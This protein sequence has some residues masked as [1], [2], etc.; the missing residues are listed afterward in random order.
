MRREMAVAMQMSA[1]QKRHHNNV[2]DNATATVTTAYRQAA[3][4]Q[5]GRPNLTGN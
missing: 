2:E 3:A 1:E 4:R 5:D